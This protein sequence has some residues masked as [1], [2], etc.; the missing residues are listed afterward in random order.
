MRIKKEKNFISMFDEKTGKYFRT[1]VIEG[2]KET[3]MDPFMASF[4]ELLDIGIMG[5]CK[6]G[7]TG[8]CLAAG[9]E[10]YQDGLHSEEPNMKLEDFRRIAEECE[11]KAFQFA[12]GGC[13]DPDQHENFKEILEICSKHKIVANFTSSGFGMNEDIAELCKTNCGAVAISWYRSEYTLRAIR[14]LLDAGVKTNIHYVLNRDTIQEAIELLQ[15]ENFPKGINA[16]I[17]LLHKPVGLGSHEKMLTLGHEKPGEQLNGQ[18]SGQLNEQLN[19]QLA[20]FFRVIEEKNHPH[21]I[22]FDSCTVPGLINFCKEIDADSVD[23]CEGGR[24]SAYI[25]P[26][27]K[28]LPCSFDNQEQRWAVDLRTHSIREAWNSDAFDSFRGSFLHACPD[29]KDRLACLGGCP[30]RPEVV[31]CNRSQRSR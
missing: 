24:W 4:P 16:V 22:G 13:G 18:S 12:L 28:M 15:K 17:F 25:T 20:K 8:R 21:K 23:T 7:R 5:H 3:E 1:G 6:H 27:M 29:C 10:C 30:I 2:G 19:G 9:V 26:D 11:G 31:L 14:L